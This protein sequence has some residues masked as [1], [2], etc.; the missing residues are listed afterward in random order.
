MSDG[1]IETRWAELRK[2]HRTALIPFLTAGYPSPPA[3]CAALEML[4]DA[5]ADLVE[6]G[7]PFSDPV[8][9]GP[10]IQ[11]A[12]QVALEGGMTLAGTLDLARHVASHVPIVIFGY[13]NPI[14]A[15]GVDRFLDDA[16]SAGVAA[17]LLTD[18]PGGEDPRIE[19]A[20]SASSLR[21]IPLVAPTTDESRCERLLRDA[22]GFVYVVARLGVTG[23]RTEVAE[24]LGQ[25]VA[26]VRRATALPVAVGFGLADG[27]QA[28]AVARIADGVVVGSAL[29]ECLDRGLSEARGLLHELRGALDEA[30]QTWVGAA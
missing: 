21:L 30:P 9:D 17:L 28:A 13:L 7:V 12:N 24:A 23:A 25:T 6:L 18:L 16:A 27:T 19:A 5:G 3:S 15:Y 10:V 20:V 14:L 8:A 26:R 22:R 11:R 2:E 4:I 29:L 1:F